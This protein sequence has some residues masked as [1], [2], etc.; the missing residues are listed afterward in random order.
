MAAPVIPGADRQFIADPGNATGATQMGDLATINLHI[1]HLLNTVVEEGANKALIVQA[2]ARTQQILEASKI[3]QARESS[4]REL[5]P[6]TRLPDVQWGD[7][8]NIANI[9]MHSVPIFTGASSDTLD[10]V[11]WISRITNLAEANTLTFESTINLMIQGSSGDAADYI[12]QLKSEGKNLAQVV[13]LLEMRFGDLCTPEEARVKTNNMARLQDESLS[14]F[15]ARIRAMANMACRM[16][17]TDATRREAV[18]LLV[19]GNIR[20]VLPT[21]VRNALG[22]RVITRS[23]MG[24][25]AFTAREIE[26]ECLDL[27]RRRD[28]R[29]TQ[30][31]GPG[32]NK[33]HRA[34]INRLAIV[35]AS[36]SSED[37]YS[38]ADEVDCEDGATYQFVNL[39]KQVQHR[40]AQKGKFAEPQKVYRKALLKFNGKYPA[41]HQGNNQPYGA[42]QVGQGGN[43]AGYSPLYQQGPPNNMEGQPRKTIMELLSL[44]NIQKGSCIQCG[45]TG[46]YMKNDQCALKDKALVDK[47][48]VKCGKGLHQADDCPIVFQRQYVAPPQAV[49]VLSQSQETLNED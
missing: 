7:R 48:C 27:E 26:K 17:D 16:E 8:R 35:P 41:K 42:R 11:R 45:V 5:R 47:A 43:A 22:E 49:N 24:L 14:K 1:L 38:S 9:R 20:R 12:E 23:S 33:Q 34:Q 37:S 40:F 32:A 10:V 21:S 36:D 31:T 25:P 2:T 18:E 19:E 46:H 3:S 15:I 28:E 6:L 29:K 44:A 13:Q 4:T 39:I 30:I